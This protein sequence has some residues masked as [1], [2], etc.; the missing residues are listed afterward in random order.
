MQ[1]ALRCPGIFDER[2][3]PPRRIDGF[4]IGLV[5]SFCSAGALIRKR[6][7]IKGASLI[8]PFPGI[9][10]ELDFFNTF[11]LGRCQWSGGLSKAATGPCKGA[12][13]FA[14]IF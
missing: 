3:G 2:S 1:F 4:V 10:G 12:A 11:N 9:F 8:C 14:R 6:D 5:P 13:A 7:R